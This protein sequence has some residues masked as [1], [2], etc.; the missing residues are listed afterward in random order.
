MKFEEYVTIDK[1]DEIA[2]KEKIYYSSTCGI[3]KIS[4]KKFYENREEEIKIIN[5]KILNH[6]YKF[7]PYKMKLIDK[8]PN[9]NPRITCIPTI[10]DRITISILKR[11]IY[12]YYEEETINIPA[13]QII[14]EIVQIRNSGEYNFFIKLDLVSF[15]SSIEH[16]VLLDI[17][18]KRISDEYVIEL[19][20]K[21]LENPQK[22]LENDEKNKN[23]SGV[24]QGL[25]I[26][27]VLAN[28]YLRDFDSKYKKM[29]EIKYYRYID[30]ILIFCNMEEKENLL[31]KI[32]LELKTKYSLQLN[33]EKLETG[34]ISKNFDYLGYKFNNKIITVRESSRINFEKN[35]ENIFKNFSRIQN[36]EEKDKLKFIW[37]LNTKITGIVSDNKKFGWLYYFSC[38]NDET[39]VRHLDKLVNKLIKRFKLE[40]IINNNQIKSFYKSY[41]EIKY[42]FKE[43]KYLLKINDIS[44]ESEIM[45][46]EKICNIKVNGINENEIDR[47]FRY[48]F[49]RTLKS[50]EKDIDNVSG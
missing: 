9:K 12:D 42:R 43:S 4:S 35:I 32:K 45:F 20:R 48:N 50:L 23:I 14:K 13:N 24:P 7:S 6:E 3:D 19:I 30:D 34:E 49:Y 22:Y 36:K 37:I 16:D 46:L 18:R 27:T 21:I 31:N 1:I 11:Y 41:K 29:K 40:Q 38:I 15:F 10:R 8:G 39:L 2:K 25:S 17:L 28:I 44:L 26:S 47:K 33:L 5:R